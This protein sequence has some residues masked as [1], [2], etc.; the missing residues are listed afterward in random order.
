MLEITDDAVVQFRKIL[1][2]SKAEEHGIRIFRQSGCC[3]PSLAMDIASGPSVGDV[4]LHK[5]GLMIYLAD[6][7]N[8][9]LE[10]ATINY[11]DEDGFIITGFQ[12]SG[13]C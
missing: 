4:T 9:M 8:R 1:S 10:N 5:D 6:D 11:T 7:A 3:G 13:C 12:Q 2:D